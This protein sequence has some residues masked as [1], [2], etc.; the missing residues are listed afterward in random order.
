MYSSVVGFTNITVLEH[1]LHNFIN[2][3]WKILYFFLNQRK[4][5]CI[6]S[7][8]IQFC[9]V[10]SSG[11]NFQKILSLEMNLSP[12]I[13]LVTIVFAM[14]KSG[15]NAQNTRAS[16]IQRPL[17]PIS[18]IFWQVGGRDCE[19]SHRVFLRDSRSL[20]DVGKLRLSM[21]SGSLGNPRVRLTTTLAICSSA[22]GPGDNSR[23]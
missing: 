3:T 18:C 13:T 8:I 4:S 14:L 11:I 19:Q 12:Q 21:A 7:Y 5:I 23:T 17:F 6:Q 15:K 20:I 9:H 16:R 1:L 10:T 22:N 2:G